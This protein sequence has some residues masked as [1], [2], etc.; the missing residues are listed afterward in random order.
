MNTVK[1]QDK[2]FKNQ[3]KVT[4][5]YPDEK[6]ISFY[7]KITKCHQEKI[8]KIYQNKANKIY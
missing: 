7:N 3:N 4:E 6:I 8:S 1:L 2:V 5:N